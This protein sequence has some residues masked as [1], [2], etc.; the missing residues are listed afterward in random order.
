MPKLSEN[1]G[2]RTAVT[3]DR[4]L[5]GGAGVTISSALVARQTAGAD[6]SP[7]IATIRR[8]EISIGVVNQT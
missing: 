8:V 7:N 2:Q 3:A 5:S 4:V 6:A 1:V